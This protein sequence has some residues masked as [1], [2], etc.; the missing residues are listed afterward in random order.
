MHTYTTYHH[1]LF[2]VFLH[3]TDVFSHGFNWYMCLHRDQGTVDT[4]AVASIQDT[5]AVASIQGTGTHVGTI[6][7]NDSQSVTNLALVLTVF[8]DWFP[9]AV[10]TTVDFYQLSQC[11]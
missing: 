1:F 3:F 7:T 10:H 2:E 6:I 8:C 9:E 5:V 11:C 4:V